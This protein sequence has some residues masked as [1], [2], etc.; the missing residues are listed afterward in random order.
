[1]SVCVSVISAFFSLVDIANGV[2]IFFRYWFEMQDIDTRKTN[3]QI[4]LSVGVCVDHSKINV[5]LDW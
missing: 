4:Y 3:N 2:C 5:P 1:M